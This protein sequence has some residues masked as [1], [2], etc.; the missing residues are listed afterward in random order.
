M[1]VA[2]ER[3]AQR[4]LREGE[5]IDELA[6]DLEKLLEKASPGLPNE[7][8]ESELR[9]YL[10][11]VL[12]EKYPFSLNCNQNVG[13]LKQLLEPRSFPSSTVEQRPRNVSTRYK[14]N[15]TTNAY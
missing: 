3:L 6:R 1:P 11:S 14:P 12:P 13:M 7:L 5:S 9:F 15:K 10:I 4:C 8:Q 2:H